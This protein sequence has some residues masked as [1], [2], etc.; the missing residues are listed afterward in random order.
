MRIR[1][2]D[3]ILI[4]LKKR[5]VKNPE[6][7]LQELEK[8]FREN[9]ESYNSVISLSSEYFNLAQERISGI[10]SNEEANRISNNLRSR[11]LAL[12]DTISLK[13]AQSFN[14][15]NSIFNKILVICKDASRKPFMASLFPEKYFKG[16]TIDAS[17]IKQDPEA[18]K[19]YDL[20]IFDNTPY[21]KEEENTLLLHYLEET[22]PLVLYFGQR[23][24]LL[25]D[26]P[27]KAYFAN[28]VFSIHTRI[29][30][31]ITYLKY[32]QE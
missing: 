4:G 24:T 3:Q 23:L 19:G 16:V 30:E 22:S 26:Y 18:V 31:M 14:F 21:S 11:I 32:K 28:S 20:V 13:E 5:V 17:G 8:I 15:K 6:Q 27:L 1:N 29:E 25:Y 2:T 10:H 12:I 9:K 7:V